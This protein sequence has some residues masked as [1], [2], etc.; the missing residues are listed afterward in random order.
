MLYEVITKAVLIPVAIVLTG[1]IWAIGVITS[2]SI[3]YTKLY[4]NRPHSCRDFNCPRRFRL[5]INR[6]ETRR[7]PLPGKTFQRK[8]TTVKT[9]QPAGTA[10]KNAKTTGKHTFYSPCRERTRITSYN[11]CYTKLLRLLML[12][13]GIYYEFIPMED[14]HKED[15]PVLSLDEIE[16]EKN[17]AMVISTNGGLWR[18]LIGDTVKFTRRNPFK[19]KITGRSYNFV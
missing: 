16:L 19:I 9:Q 14:F 17:Y 7:R 1:V 18:Y 5:E 3:H 12:D 2:Y 10:P 4:E 15:R 11:V 8:G 13:Y 6:A